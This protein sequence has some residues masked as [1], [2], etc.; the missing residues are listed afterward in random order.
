MTTFE[1]NRLRCQSLSQRD[2]IDFEAGVEPSW[3]G[4][5]NPYKHLTEGPSPLKHRIPRVKREPEFAE[6]GLF[7]AIEKASNE[8]IGSA[9]FHDFP[10]EKGMI[11]IGFGIVPEKQNQGFGT[12]LLIGMW[13]MICLRPDVRLLRYTV[14]P[15]NLPSM[16][17]I[18]KLE[19]SKVG[20]QMDP[21]DGLELIYERLSKD[22]QYEMPP[23]R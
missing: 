17:I 2:Y 20:Q 23:I 1:T 7:L 12:E 8:I 5:S 14:S 16:H 13:K 15:E 18:K 9:G 4:F 22:F 3:N 6:I 21:K 19:F 11:E 10:D